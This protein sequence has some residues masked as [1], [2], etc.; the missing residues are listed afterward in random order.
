MCEHNSLSLENERL[1]Y[2]SC[3]G[4]A[5]VEFDEICEE[6]GEKIGIEIQVFVYNYTFYR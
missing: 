1:V 2:I 4:E 3:D 5:H 6:C